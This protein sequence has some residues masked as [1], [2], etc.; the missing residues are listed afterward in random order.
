MRA[1]AQL[2][3][4]YKDL[5]RRA[6][7]G[8]RELPVAVKV[9]LAFAMACATGLA[10]TVRLPLPFTP[11]PVT[12]QTLAV[13]LSGVLLGRFYGG[14]SQALY[15]GLGA[16]GLPWFILGSG[17]LLGPTGGYLVGFVAAAAL[18]G[19]TNDRCPAARGFRPQLALMSGA[20]LLILLCGAAHLALMPG[21]GAG[22]A[23]LIG[24]LPFLPGDAVKSFIAASVAS[25]LMPKASEDAP[26]A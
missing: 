5:R 26:T 6:F 13:L 2:W 24:V 14:L 17:G 25:A 11:V 21:V 3:P 22:R 9:G 10:A 23:V 4:I 1:A 12:G 20:S 18:I 15:V 7:T 8:C 19:Y 16:V